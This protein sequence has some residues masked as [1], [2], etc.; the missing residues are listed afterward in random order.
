ML[1]KIYSASIFLLI[2]LSISV[3][4]QEYNPNEVIVKF[5]TKNS[6]AIVAFMKQINLSSFEVLFPKLDNDLNQIYKLKFPSNSDILSLVYKC[7]NDPVVQYAQ[8][9]FCKRLAEKMDKPN[10]FFYP[11]QWALDKIDLLKAWEIEKGS[12]DIVIAVIDTGVDYKHEDLRSRIWTNK[13]EIP[14]NNI[15]DDGNGYID[16]VIGWDFFDSPTTKLK[17]DHIDRDNDPMD[18]DGHGTHIA[19]IIAGIP[20][21]SIGIAGITWGC[22]IM[23]LRAGSKILEDDDLASA[24]VYAVENGAKIINMSWGDDNLSFV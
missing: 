1:K 8:P 7:K 24:I 12:E 16:D 2:F 6:K 21:N 17:T 20:N 5:N 23:A 22:K 4:A 14:N 19:G 10:D 15:D 18:E 3:K 9:N 13:G 11:N